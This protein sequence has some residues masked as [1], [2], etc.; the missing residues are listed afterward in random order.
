MTYRYK[1]KNIYISQIYCGKEIGKPALMLDVYGCNRNCNYCNQND[2]Y[3][4][5]EK[6]NKHRYNTYSLDELLYI[7]TEFDYKNI[8][9]GGS[10]EPTLINGLYDLVEILING[11]YN[12]IIETNGKKFNKALLIATYVIFNIKTFSAGTPYTKREDMEWYKERTNA[13]FSCTISDIKD[14]DYL[15]TNFKDYDIWLFLEF[16]ELDFNP[17]L[18]KILVYDN[19]RLCFRFDKISNLD[20]STVDKRL[21]GD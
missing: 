16:D 18:E 4:P 3:H 20:F 2:Y 1:L 11:G 14:I 15:V 19:W 5:Y 6:Y 17:F 12:V 9:I 13:I 8:I 7:I 21:K 10:G